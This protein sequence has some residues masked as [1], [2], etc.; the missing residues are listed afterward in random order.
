[1]QSE[2]G[3]EFLQFSQDKWIVENYN[4]KLVSCLDM[5]FKYIEPL[6]IWRLVSLVFESH[7]YT[8]ID[9]LT[10]TKKTNIMIT[11]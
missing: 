10:C 1:M 3:F 11:R 7:W 2:Y 6:F 5:K 4:K 8:Q 9:E